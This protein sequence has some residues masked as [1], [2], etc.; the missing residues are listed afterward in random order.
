MSDYAVAGGII[1]FEVN[2][3]E[4]AGQ[5]IREATIK[6][7]GSQALIKVTLWPEFAN[8]QIKKGDTIFVDGKYETSL[9]QA[10]DG[11]ERQYISISATQISVVP[12]AE[13]LPRDVV[14]SGSSAAKSNDAPLF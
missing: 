10:A 8:V 12:A 7:F 13:K 14:K 9:G 3:K 4:A 1:Q 6:A 2:E 11:S 5:A